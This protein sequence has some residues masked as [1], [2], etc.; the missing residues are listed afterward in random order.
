MRL[1]QVFEPPMCCSTGVCG[2]E[3]DPTLVQFAAD[4]DSLRND[5]VKIER[6]NLS[7]N[8][9]QFATTPAVLTLLK[10]KGADA[11]PAI[12]ADGRLVHSGSYPDSGA[13]RAMVAALPRDAA[14]PSSIDRAYAALDSGHAVFLVHGGDSEFV[15]PFRAVAANPAFCD[16]VVL[17]E[18]STDKEPD[19]ALMQEAGLAAG[20]VAAVL[21]APPGRVIAHWRDAADE[22][23]VL[24]RALQASQPSSCC[25][26]AS[27]CCS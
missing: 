14:P 25:S 20:E 11:L 24:I 5:G 7:Q 16:S 21:I 4:I 26:P 27:S 19:R 3:V 15:K 18:L 22:T 12:L 9:N 8:P 10:T 13:L 17:L 2:P 6:F 1:I 23:D